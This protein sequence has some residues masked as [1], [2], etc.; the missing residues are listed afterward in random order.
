MSFQSGHQLPLSVALRSKRD[1]RT[2]F[3]ALCYRIKNDKTQVLLVTSRGRRRWI[4]PKGWPER[5]LTPAQGAMRE[6]WEEAGVKGQPID[7]CLG[8]FS[9][10]KLDAKPARLPCLALVFPVKVRKLVKDYP[11]AGQRRRKWVSPKR[12]ASM[13]AEVELK[14][15]LRNFDA[16][17][18]RHS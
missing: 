6:A 1:M 3:A 10:L 2:Q 8:V 5:G 7:V 9:Y 16:K 15:I 13:V 14:E 4:L 17:R 12:A 11:E 18:L